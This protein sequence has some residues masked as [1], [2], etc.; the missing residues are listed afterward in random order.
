MLPL[1]IPT[2]PLAAPSDYGYDP[3]ANPEPGGAHINQTTLAWPAF[4]AVD[5][6]LAQQDLAAM[7]RQF[8]S[9]GY[10]VARGII[11]PPALDV[12]IGLHDALVSGELQAV[13]SAARED[14]R[15]GGLESAT[16]KVLWGDA[17]WSR[18]QLL[19]ELARGNWGVCR[20]HS[21]DIFAPEEEHYFDLIRS[22]RIVYAPHSSMTEQFSDEELEDEAANGDG[23]VS[24]EQMARHREELRARLVAD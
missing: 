18:S 11:D 2:Q 24:S 14:A 15:R 7:R 19:G 6:W 21:L 13:C 10:V 17:R 3:S 16:V 22:E 23:R 12:Y 8:D 4:T 1:L 5:A 20:A 9:D